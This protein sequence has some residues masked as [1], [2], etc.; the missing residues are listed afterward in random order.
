MLNLILAG[1]AGAGIAVGLIYA[2]I[3]TALRRALRGDS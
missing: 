3:A 1:I 2:L